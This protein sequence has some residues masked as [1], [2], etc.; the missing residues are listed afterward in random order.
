MAEFSFEKMFQM[1]ADATELRTMA[2]I[3]LQRDSSCAAR[4]PT[5]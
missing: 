2:A 3:E 4:T 5:T 1:G